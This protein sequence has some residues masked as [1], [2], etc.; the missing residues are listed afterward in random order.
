MC[1]KVDLNWGFEFGIQ[2]KEKAKEKINK[3]KE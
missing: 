1:H 3:E 2:N